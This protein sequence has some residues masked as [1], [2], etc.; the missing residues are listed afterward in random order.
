MIPR[1]RRIP[2]GSALDGDAHAAGR[3][4][5][6]AAGVLAIIVNPRYGP[7]TSTALD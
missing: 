3:P 5:D 7:T 2:T 6:H 4:L 1:I